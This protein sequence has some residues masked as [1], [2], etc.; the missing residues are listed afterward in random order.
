M[1]EAGRELCTPT[2][3]ALLLSLAKRFGPTPALSVSAVGS[4]ETV[5]REIDALV[6]T[7]QPDEQILTGNIHDPEKRLRSFRLAAEALA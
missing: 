7:H 1:P 6:A 3:A 2:G 4:P 5:R